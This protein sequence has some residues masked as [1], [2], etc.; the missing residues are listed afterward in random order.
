MTPITVSN[1]D[2]SMIKCH[3][4]EQRLYVFDKPIEYYN[5]K[6]TGCY[7]TYVCVLISATVLDGNCRL[8]RTHRD[9]AF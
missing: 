6:K 9:V 3:G 1:F 8:A 5:Q 4:T 2:E 7:C